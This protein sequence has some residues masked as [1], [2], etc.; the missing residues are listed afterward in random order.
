MSYRNFRKQRGV[1]LI[2]VLVGVTVGLIILAG[3]VTVM[4]NLSF[5][6][7]ENTRAMRLNHQ[8]R[9]TLDFIH[10][11]L[12]RAGYVYSWDETVLT[13][14]EDADT[15]VMEAALGLA[16]VINFGGVA[17]DAD[18]DGYQE[19]SCITFTYDAN[20]NGITDADDDGVNDETD[21][22]FGFRLN[23]GA[24]EGGTNVTCANNLNWVDITDAGITITALSFEREEYDA[25]A[26]TGDSQIFEVNED[27][28]V[29]AGCGAGDIC[30]DRRTIHVVLE[31][32]LATD[33]AVTVAL[34]DEVKVKNDHYYRFDDLP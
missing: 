32:Q 8:L 16:G 29:E 23:G 5:S 14:W 2:E 17:T 24:V 27:G 9:S 26:D 22:I 12:Q 1:T 15:D 31:G 34:R 13:T 28:A 30:L 4:A 7:L 19:F 20:D 33:A 3:A 21:E 11:D 18:G 10:R 25:V 6:G